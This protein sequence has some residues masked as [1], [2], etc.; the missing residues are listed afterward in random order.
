MLRDFEDPIKSE[1]DRLLYRRQCA[2]VAKE[3]DCAKGTYLS[4]KVKQCTNDPNELHTITDKLL[5][6][7]HQQ[8]LP[9]DE[10][11]S[12]LANRFDAFFKSKID[13]IRQHFNLNVDSREQILSNIELSEM[14]PATIEEVRKLITSCSNKSCEMDPVPTWHP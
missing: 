7:Q 9:S 13:N 4:T 10:D 6:K 2:V 5:V 8:T 1:V 3:L 11:H 14:R 12:H